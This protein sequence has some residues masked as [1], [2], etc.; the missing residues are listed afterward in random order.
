AKINEFSPYKMIVSPIVNEMAF[1]QKR[2][3]QAKQFKLTTLVSKYFVTPVDCARPVILLEFDYSMKSGC[4][5]GEYILLHYFGK[6]TTTRAYTPITPQFVLCEGGARLQSITEQ[7]HN[8][9]NLSQ[10][11]NSKDEDRSQR[12]FLLVRLYKYGNMSNILRSLKPGQILRITG[13]FLRKPMLPTYT[14]EGFGLQCWRRV[15]M[16]CGGTGV[17]PMLH[18]IMH[19]LSQ[20]NDENKLLLLWFN[21][22]PNDLFVA[23]HLR[24]LQL[25]FPKRLYFVFCFT[26]SETGQ[27]TDVNALYNLKEWSQVHFKKWED[28]QNRTL[29]RHFLK[30]G[31]PPHETQSSTKSDGNTA[32]DIEIGKLKSESSNLQD[33]HPHDRL[34]ISGPKPFVESYIDL[35]K[36]TVDFQKVNLGKQLISLD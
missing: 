16:I 36:D 8:Q 6:D 35:M 12:L 4:L 7:P 33:L 25:Q 18:V 26:A 3:K 14:D 24:Y 11:K 19:H 10:A 17:T 28:T 23:S 1:L 5:L 2:D 13:P 29:I 20:G 15:I 30:H 31:E 9:K 27:V 21:N 32:G 34:M 22:T